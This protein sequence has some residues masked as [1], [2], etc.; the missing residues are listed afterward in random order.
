M[1]TQLERL[2]H[3]HGRFRA[4][5]ARDVTGRQHHAAPSAA[6]NHGFVPQARIVALF[7]GSVEGVAIQM[8]DPKL[9]RVTIRQDAR[10]PA[11]GADRRT[12]RR[13][14]TG[15]R[16]RSSYSWRAWGG[17]GERRVDVSLKPI[18]A[19]MEM[20]A[21][22]APCL[23]DFSDHLTAHHFV[24][25]GHQ[26][27]ALM[28]VTG[29]NAVPVVEDGKAAIEIEIADERNDAVCGGMN[30]RAGRRGNVHGQMRR[31]GLPIQDL[32]AAEQAADDTGNR[33]IETVRNQTAS[34][35]RACTLCMISLSRL[36][37]ATT[38]S[39]GVTKGAGKPE[40]RWIS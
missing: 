8:R 12:G 26:L 9:L 32:L 17:R 21:G 5:F 13:R 24:A 35:S 25:F 16:G 22:G 34:V 2:K 18:H 31:P 6:D 14:T 33:P 39:G 19:P 3:R 30:R 11:R 23:S 40:I 27:F 4:E 7:D 10:A 1:R 37:R 29:R 15:N 28:T 20:R 38:S 36:M